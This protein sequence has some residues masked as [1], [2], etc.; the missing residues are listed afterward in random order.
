MTTTFIILSFL[1][2]LL[3]FLPSFRITHWLVQVFDYIRI[4]VL[5]LQL[6]IVI[7]S[8]LFVEEESTLLY[9]SQVALLIAI[10][11]QEYIIWPYVPLSSIFTNM[12]PVSYDTP[13]NEI[14]NVTS[15]VWQ[16]NKD[17]HREIQS[18]KEV[19]PVNLLPTDTK[20]A[21][22]TALHAHE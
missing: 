3:S 13:G 21:W 11:Y 6:A 18:M 4:Q 8:L 22:A 14:Y 10:A 19:H 12:K 5:Y 2:F 1:L 15:N 20:E 7:A 16:K 9:L 17:Y